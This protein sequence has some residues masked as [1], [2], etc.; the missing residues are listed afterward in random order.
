MFVV[1]FHAGSEVL[2]GVGEQL[3]GAETDQVILAYIW[4]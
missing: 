4:I 2:L 1:S 3:V